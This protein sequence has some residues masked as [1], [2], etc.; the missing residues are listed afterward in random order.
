MR[1][2]EGMQTSGGYIQHETM[3]DTFT[4][5]PFSEFVNGILTVRTEALC[6][7]I[8]RINTQGQCHDGVTACH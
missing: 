1:L 3:T 2:S 6:V 8:N 5:Y 4:I 7:V